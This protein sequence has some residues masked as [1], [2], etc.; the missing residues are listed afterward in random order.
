M[1]QAGDATPDGAPRA[2]RRE[3]SAL[4]TH[5][6]LAVGLALCAVAFWFE[7]HRALGGNELSWAYV[8]EW[9]LLG[10]FAVY[11]WWRV[12]HPD[13]RPRRIKEG[14]EGPEVRRMREAWEEYRQTLH[15]EP[16]N[17]TTDDPTGL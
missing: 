16:E 8:F 10:G 12:L 17:A 9:P 14:P 3:G 15:A 7:L 4:R 5:L 1:E 11:M 6:T 13:E 2:R